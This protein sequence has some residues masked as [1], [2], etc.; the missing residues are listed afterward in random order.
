MNKL[1]NSKDKQS[2]KVINIT[3]LFCFFDI[4]L[5]ISTNFLN[6]TVYNKKEVIK[7]ETYIFFCYNSSN[8]WICNIL[9]CKKWK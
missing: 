2:N 9:S 5:H 6:I 3:K 4:K 1:N 8:K 7:M